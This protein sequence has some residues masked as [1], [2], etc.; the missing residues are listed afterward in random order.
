[1]WG[2]PPAHLAQGDH[3][4]KPAL[5]LAF[6][7]RGKLE[8]AAFVQKDVPE[9]GLK[10]LAAPNSGV[11][12]ADGGAAP[13]ATSTG[14]ASATAT[15][16]TSSSSGAGSSDKKGCNAGAGDASAFG[17]IAFGLLGLIAARRRK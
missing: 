2:G 4:V 3:G 14:S 8:L 1:V 16:S 15:A 10:G 12:P 17:A 5:N 11:G 6:A 13:A 7:P 9:I